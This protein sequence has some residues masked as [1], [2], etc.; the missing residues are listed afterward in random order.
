MKLLPGVLVLTAAAL[1]AAA[2]PILDGTR[3][4]SYDLRS[5]QTVQTQFGDAN[6]A[7]GSELDAAYARVEG[8]T[9]YLMLTGNLENNFNKLNIF[10]DSVA[11]GENV[12]TNDANNGGDNPANDG[13]AGK[14]AG[15][16]FDTGFDADY[17]LILRNGNFGG[18]Q[19]NVD[20]VAIGGGA[21]AFEAATDIFGGSLTGSNANALPVAGIGVAFDNSN[22]GGVLGGTGAANQ[23]AAAAVMTGIELAIPLSALGNPVGDILISAMI[24]GSNHDYLSNQ[25]LGGLTPPQGN[26][27]GDGNGAFNG[28]VGQINLQSGSYAAGD[29]FFSVAA[30]SSVPEPSTMA[31]IGLGL[32]GMLGLGRRRRQ[33]GSGGRPQLSSHIHTIGGTP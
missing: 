29:Q 10:F 2:A 16:T 1:P 22:T 14:Y 26:L 32:A 9:L 33:Y 8:G 25:F 19:F 21:G 31:L 20:F 18:N 28:T 5:V 12:L 17:L 4:A 3:D 15:F 13:W 11:G 7:G 6:P 23:A 24:N 30:P 27:G